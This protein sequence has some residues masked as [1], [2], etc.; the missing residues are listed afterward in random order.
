MSILDHLR[1]RQAARPDED[2][3]AAFGKGRADCGDIDCQTPKIDPPMTSHR[4]I[5][6]EDPVLL[7]G[8]FGGTAEK[9]GPGELG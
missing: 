8:V 3:E 4:G 5:Y 9:C 6:F 2:I 7:E 1:F